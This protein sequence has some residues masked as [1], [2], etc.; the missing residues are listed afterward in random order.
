MNTTVIFIV[1]VGLLIA[2]FDVYIIA[3][4]G[5]TESISAHIIRVSHKY[6]SIPFLLGFLC[7]HL[8][9]SMNTADWLIN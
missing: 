7:G 2:I 6:P 8:F 9:W 5:K 3:K 4:K 1:S